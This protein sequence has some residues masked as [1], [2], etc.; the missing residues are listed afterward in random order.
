MKHLSKFTAFL[1][2]ITMCLGVAVAMA[3]DKKMSMTIDQLTLATDRNGA[4]YARFIID[5]KR[6]I[7][8]VGYE[9]GVPVMVFG[10]SN[11]A[12]YDQIAAMKNGDKITAICSSREYQGRKSY[13]MIA[14][15]P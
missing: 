4:P 6:Q 7:E 3:E 14:L 9:V 1:L 15:V 12:L 11:K 10:G 13:T 2:V 8:G 5:E